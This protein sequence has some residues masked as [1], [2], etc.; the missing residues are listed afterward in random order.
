MKVV[1]V[2]GSPNVKGNTAKVLGW[3][4]DELRTRK[5]KVERINIIE[6]NLNYCLACYQCQGYPDEPGCAQD[7]DD[8][9]EIFDSLMKS[10]AIVLASPLYM[11]NF[12]APMK[13]F[14]DRCISLVTGYTSSAH[15][16]LIEGKR[17]AL[18]V[19]CGGPV[20]GNAEL[21]RENYRRMERF[22]KTLPSG[23]L[24]VP[25]CTTPDAMGDE[26]RGQARH[27]THQLLGD[28]EFGK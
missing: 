14:L 28:V 10:D 27:L 18:L 5:H 2:L 23:E 1:T 15:K 26:I 6:K 16:S 19:T 7:D 22:A 25:F 12:A 21:I 11:W 20:E 17:T 9:M 24:I 3:V 13:V 8:A 4:E